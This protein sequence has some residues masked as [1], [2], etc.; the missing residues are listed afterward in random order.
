VIAE[1]AA[2]QLALGLPTDVDG[3]SSLLRRVA[4]TLTCLQNQQSRRDDH[5]YRRPGLPH[6][7]ADGESTVKLINRRVKGNENYWSERGAERRLAP[8]ADHLSTSQPLTEF[9]RPRPPNPVAAPTPKPPRGPFPLPRITNGVLHSVPA[10]ACQLE[11][12]RGRRGCREKLAATG[13]Q[14]HSGGGPSKSRFAAAG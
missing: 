12:S 7:S 2:R 6:A 13:G 1:L 5:A 14:M 4:V 10:G 8:T 11:R 9:W 3:E